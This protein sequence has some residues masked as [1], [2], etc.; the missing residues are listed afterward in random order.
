MMSEL[1][2]YVPAHRIAE[3]KRFVLDKHSVIEENIESH[4]NF[5]AF[6][7]EFIYGKIED[8]K[9]QVEKDVPKKEKSEEEVFDEVVANKLSHV[10]W[11][12][13]KEISWSI[14]VTK[15]TLDNVYSI[16]VCT[17]TS[18]LKRIVLRDKE[19]SLRFLSHI[20]IKFLKGIIWKRSMQS[21]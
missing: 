18:V 11:D 1:L 15:D 10:K 19:K 14:A 3:F 21:Q 16:E 20:N 6:V 7:S 5:E 13:V 2:K 12:E 4:D 9:E 8:K 17:K